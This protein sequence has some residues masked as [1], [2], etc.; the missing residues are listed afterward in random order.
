[1]ADASQIGAR[2]T[3]GRTM[4]QGMPVELR[5][6]PQPRVDVVS[7]DSPDEPTTGVHP[8]GTF[9][10]RDPVVRIEAPED[11]EERWASLVGAHR[12]EIEALRCE[13]ARATRFLDAVATGDVERVDSLSS[14]LDRTAPR[15]TCAPTEIADLGAT[16]EVSEDGATDED[17]ATFI[18][19]E[20]LDFPE[21]CAVEWQIR[22]MLEGTAG[23]GS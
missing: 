10:A 6:V 7:W 21:A 17:G 1:M 15:L 13:L 14:H 9:A 2:E 16:C 5:A 19:P 11:A 18:D 8:I 3:T 20:E 23:T 4:A 22:A 12:T